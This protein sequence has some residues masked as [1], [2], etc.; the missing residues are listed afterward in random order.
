M[1]T[2]ERWTAGG[3]ARLLPG[4]VA[5]SVV[6]LAT[7]A[8]PLAARAETLGDAIALAYESNPTL[9]AQR[10]SLRALDET[11]VQAEA[12]Y[13][14]SANLQAIVTTDKNDYTGTTQRPLPGQSQPVIQGQSQT[15]G[16]AIGLSQ[17][18]YTGG[19]VATQ[20]TAAEAQILAGRETV[21]G[22]E[23]TTL[24]DVITAY[25]D[26]RRDQQF[27]TILEE[28]QR[29]LLAQQDEVHAR[30]AVGEITRT[31]VAETEARVAASQAQ[32][33]SARAQLGNSRAEYASVVGQSPGTLAPEPPLAGR[34]P[35][36][37]EVAFQ[38]AERNSPPIRQADF[39]EQSSA[40]KVA[41][42]KADTRP[43]LALQ[44]SAGYSGGTFASP[45][46]PLLGTAAVGGLG[47]PFRNFS[48]DVT[49]SAVLTVPLF[50][51]GMTS[52][53]IRQAAET[54][55]AD[56][57]GIEVARRQVLLTVSQAWNG[58]N[59]ARASLPVDVAQV[60]AANIAYE[61]SRQESRVG[62]RSTL[63][64][65]I[66][67]QNLAAAQIALVTAR[68]DEYVAAAA[69]LGATGTLFAGDFA[70]DTRIYDPKVNFANIRRSWPWTPW[71]PA[72]ADLDKLGAPAI[73]VMPDPTPPGP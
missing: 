43:S 49:A 13:R 72:V 6:A 22:T 39:T 63:D 10:A 7:G 25:A 36:S 57:I 26:V 31:D 62:L 71:T 32:L 34:L 55:N 9:Q 53:R 8:L 14:P 19:R 11:Y 24:R 20:V 58:L 18:L 4:A 38:W 2:A 21:R 33:E 64:V 1:A 37:L 42:A 70:P 47:T 54:N 35:P 17:P 48:Y 15:S 61:G 45:A 3:R 28:D 29:L 30:F 65:L 67:E 60:K 27:V 59:G 73:R 40:A 69:L 46:N 50:T 56:R 5:A 41:E 44:A 68:H 23:E 66:A 12:G 52:S 16:F 51:G